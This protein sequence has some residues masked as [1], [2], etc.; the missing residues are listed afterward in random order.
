MTNQ[1]EPTQ[2]TPKSFVSKIDNGHRGD[3]DPESRTFTFDDGFV[4]TEETSKVPLKYLVTD[5]NPR[6]FF[7]HEKFQ[8]FYETIK[9]QGVNQN[10]LISPDESRRLVVVAGG[11]RTGVAHMV[12]DLEYQMPVHFKPMNPVER[13]LAA[14][15]ENAQREDLGPIEESKQLAKLM[16]DTTDLKH[17]SKLLGWNKDKIENRKA[18]LALSPEAMHCIV[19]ERLSL[20]MAELLAVLT[21]PKQNQIL[22]VWRENKDGKTPLTEA[23]IKKLIAENALSL[24]DAVFDKSDCAS[25]PHNS[26]IQAA[27]F[28]ENIGQAERCTNGGCYSG[29][30]NAA[31]ESLVQEHKVN[32][33]RVEIVNHADRERVTRVIPINHKNA[34]G[35]EQAQACR[36]CANFGA[37]VSNIPGSI[38]KVMSGQCFDIKCHSTKV[39]EYQQAIA[40]ATK[41]TKA[42]KAGDSSVKAKQPGKNAPETKPTSGKADPKSKVTEVALSP[43]LKEYRLAAFKSALEKDI[44]TKPQFAHALLLILAEKRLLSKITIK[45]GEAIKDISEIPYVPAKAAQMLEVITTFNQEQQVQMVLQMVATSISQLEERDVIELM[46]LISTELANYWVIDQK[47]LNTITKSEI[48]LMCQDLKIADAIPTYKALLAKSKPELVAGILGS[49]FTFKGAIPKFMKI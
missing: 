27:L 22:Q 3:W 26:S 44:G 36:G 49:D 32:F 2:D 37:A 23:A 1:T 39:A 10:V 18:L 30:T 11:R 46:K 12:F 45:A 38:G 20:Q 41:E 17:L 28:A 21:H 5:E 14:A 47:L 8:S 13:G 35:E 19:H 33:P 42:Q 7:S 40:K 15:T 25:C 6:E 9:E 34:V 24:V 16:I 4:V 48:D 43:S 31:L 29:K